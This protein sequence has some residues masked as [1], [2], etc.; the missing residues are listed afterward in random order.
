MCI[1][2][3]F[4]YEGFLEVAAEKSSY[5]FISLHSCDYLCEISILTNVVTDR[6]SGRNE[7]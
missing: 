4:T 5:Q 1:Y 2:M 6:N 7:I 3:I